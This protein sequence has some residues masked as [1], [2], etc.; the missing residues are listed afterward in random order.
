MF[1]KKVRNT[2]NTLRLWLFIGM[3][4]KRWVVSL[5]FSS[6]FLGMSVVYA[7]I[8]LRS[9]GL[10]PNWLRVLITFDF[11]NNSWFRLLLMLLLGLFCLFFS[12]ARLGNTLV[13]PF[14]KPDQS[15]VE[16]LW[17]Y[18][19]Q[20][21]GPNIVLIGGGTGMPALVRGLAPSTRNL[22]AIVT[23]ADDG[24]S[25]GRLRR[26]LG[27]LPPGDFRNNI[28]AL[29][30]DE[31]LMTQLMQYRFGE[32]VDA[33]Q[34]SQLRGH[35]FGNLLIAALTG[36][37]G[38]F[39]EG[40]VAI[41][42]V[43]A[44]HGQVMP[45]T[46]QDVQLSADIEIDG[47]VERIIGE[48]NL[49]ESG[50]R[51]RRVYL[52]PN[53]VRAYPSTIRAILQADLVVMGPGSLF[54]SVLPNLLVREIAMAVGQ[55]KAKTV[56][57]CNVAE[58]KGETD[59]FCAGDHLQAIHENAPQV[60]IDYLLANDNLSVPTETGGGQT[61]Y[62]LPEHHGSEKLILA[63]LVDVTRPWRHDSK[64]VASQLLKLL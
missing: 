62:V 63:D 45:S 42:R 10:L 61:I 64:K 52:E 37:T 57:V 18:Q 21:R 1:W 7:L 49:P 39:E 36:I 26:E 56:Y 48:S 8:L 30:K 9:H 22:T 50:G 38:S 2:L 23:V 24:G 55:T 33:Q 32:N 60:R 5:A 53:G 28:T 25:S 27:I 3:G 13:A 46:L 17:Q 51:I 19:T 31:G 43:L 14:R 44:L 6:A 54:T 15:V 58:Q 40:L 16:S 35:A 29:A 47:R 20:N 11:V 34:P 59:G 4:V 41:N 12:L